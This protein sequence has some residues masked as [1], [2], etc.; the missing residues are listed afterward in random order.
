ML[1]DAD[2]KIIILI[3]TII[4]GLIG[5]G[6]VI[7][8]IR[9]RNKGIRSCPHC[10]HLLTTGNDLRCPECGRVAG[11][12]RRALRANRTPGNILWGILL[13]GGAIF[14]AQQ[15]GIEQ[16]NIYRRLPDRI[17][18]LMLPYSGGH[19]RVGV[20]RELS[21]RLTKGRL[22]DTTR[23]AL[24][25]RLALG[26][27]Q[28]RPGTPH[29]RRKYG[30]LIQTLRSTVK[31]DDP[32]NLRFNELKPVVDFELPRFWPEDLPV[33]GMFHLTR[34]DRGRNLAEVRIEGLGPDAT[35]FEHHQVNRSACP[36]S[37]PLPETGTSTLPVRIVTTDDDGRRRVHEVDLRVP[38]RPI[39]DITLEP[40]DTP[41][42]ETTLRTGVFS[43]PI[44]FHA[45]GSPPW[46][47]RFQPRSTRRVRAFQD[48]LVGVEVDLILDERVAR[49]SWIW[50]SP[51]EADAAWET[52]FEQPDLLQQIRT[53]PDDWSLRVT[54]RREIAARALVG[55]PHPPKF[56]WE[57][58]YTTPIETVLRTGGMLPREWERMPDPTPEH[59]EDEDPVET[60]STVEK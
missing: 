33:I 42:M 37:L 30:M 35:T 54:G 28:A 46:S 29:W 18:T 56:Y 59:L 36:L 57:G 15:L 6:L 2:A 7:T 17:L 40:R 3:M 41:E 50:W 44:S 24:F 58:T 9:G 19:G 38:R 55:T 45:S 16:V 34:F 48:T 32:L 22:E 51:R 13:F 31:D 23:A 60:G 49:R 26:D 1:L 12:E 14:C 43:R 53:R 21:E 11:S 20:Q 5:L 4:V 47:L 25:E 52:I 27:G 39:R 10:R 8:G